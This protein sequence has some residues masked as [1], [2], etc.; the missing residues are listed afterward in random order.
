MSDKFAEWPGRLVL[1]PLQYAGGTA[2]M[3]V[4]KITN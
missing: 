4:G 2:E 1:T 3:A